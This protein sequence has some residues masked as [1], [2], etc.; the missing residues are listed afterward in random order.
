[1]INSFTPELRQRFLVLTPATQATLGALH[2]GQTRRSKVLT[3]R[4]VKQEIL[5]EYQGIAAAVATDNGEQ[6]ANSARWLVDHRIP[7]G[8]L[9]PY[10]PLDKINV[11]SLTVLPA[12]N[13]VVEGAALKL[14]DAADKGNMAAPAK[15]LGDI[16]SG[17]VT[18]HQFFRGQ[19][20]ISPLLVSGAGK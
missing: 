8:G 9:L 14:A 12:M 4:Q 1:M 19:P 5:S 17:C 2:A 20:G 18:C 15:W 13:G 11:A 7:V 16:T 6:A 3:L 10:I